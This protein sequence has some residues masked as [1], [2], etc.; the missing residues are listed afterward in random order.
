MDFLFSGLT[1]ATLFVFRRR[2]P[3]ASGAGRV[4][5]LARVPGHPVTTGLFVAVVWLV[6]INTIAKYPVNTAIGF[7]IL[8]AGIPVYFAWNRLRRHGA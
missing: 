1:A 8:L 4:S 7:G 5:A 2:D 3:E 6:V